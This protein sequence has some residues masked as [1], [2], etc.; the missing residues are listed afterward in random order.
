MHHF[1][2]RA[3]AL[4]IAALL[5]GCSAAPV[6]E[7]SNAVVITSS[8]TGTAAEA[9]EKD[10]TTAKTETETVTE[11]PSV[12]TEATE[13][14]T[15][16]PPPPKVTFTA[17]G[18]N[19]IHS[20]I[21]KQ[22]AARAEELDYTE[23][24]FTYA[25]E[26]VADR[27]GNA[28]ISIINQETIIANGELEPD[29][30]PCFNS[31]VELGDHMRK[32]GFDIFCMANNHVLDKSAK[33]LEAALRYYDGRGMIRVGA[34][35]DEDDRSKV[36]IVEENGMRIAFL[37]YTEHTNGITL[38]GDSP[39]TYGSI[40]DEDA[41]T[42]ALYETETAEKKSDAVI[43]MLH[44]GTED[45][46]VIDSYQRPL[47]QR[48]ADAGADV[49]LGSHPHVLRNM[50]WINRDDG[51]RTLCVYSMGNFISAQYE[52]P[53][54]IG[55][56]LDFALE[57]NGERPDVKD[58]R[59]TPT[60]THYDAHFADLRLYLY[61]DYTEELAS[62]HGMNAKRSFTL[63]YITEYLEGHHLIGRENIVDDPIK[64]D[65]PEEEEEE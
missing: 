43:V 65:E 19:L 45:S 54:L 51:G 28:D 59:F 10:E 24:D 58:I 32:L 46:D 38:P 16:A 35:R 34:Y 63:D 52:R 56:I 17:V 39:L 61:Q 3:F 29:D 36:R 37:A 44:W 40:K 55:G 9:E 62:R 42:R 23:Y 18:D 48:F 11:A 7:S 20:T 21:Y 26:N 64:T 33:G 57:L 25:Y 1:R 50:E 2:K 53:N 8:Q 13:T 31:P 14:A 6:D 22:A 41:I 4:I 27:L 15:E 12:E 5:C 30:Y 60:V 47:A 49:I